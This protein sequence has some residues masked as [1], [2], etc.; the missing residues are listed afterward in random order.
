[1]EFSIKG[2]NLSKFKTD[3]I[4]VGVYDSK[5]LSADAKSLDAASK[6]AIAHAAASGDISGKVGSTLLL[7]GLSG[8]GA[9]RVLLVGM[10]DEKQYGNVAFKSALVSA[11]KVLKGTAVT[12]VVLSLD[13][14]HAGDLAWKVEQACILAIEGAYRFNQMNST[15]ISVAKNPYVS[16]MNSVEKL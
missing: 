16:R 1:M 12:D 13:T 9:K 10:G 11:F 8:I 15:K 5:K 14:R 2:G 4:I 6:G 3:C 7:H